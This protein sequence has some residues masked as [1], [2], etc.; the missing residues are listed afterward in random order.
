[1]RQNSPRAPRVCSGGVVE[2]KHAVSTSYQMKH[3]LALQ[4]LH[5]SLAFTAVGEAEPWLQVLP[6]SPCLLSALLVAIGASLRRFLMLQ[7]REYQERIPQ[8][9]IYLM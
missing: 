9:T 6:T 7:L 4:P 2:R 8:I 3:S 5:H 1:M